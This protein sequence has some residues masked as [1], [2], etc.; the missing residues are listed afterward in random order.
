MK[1]PKYSIEVVYKDFLGITN[2]VRWVDIVWNRAVIPRSRFVVWL[3]YHDRLKTKQRLMRVGV[4][5]E[6]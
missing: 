5:E 3:A 4:V 1:S 2:K 6:N